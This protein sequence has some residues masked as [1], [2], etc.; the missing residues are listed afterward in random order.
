MVL[1]FVHVLVALDMN[2]IDVERLEMCNGLSDF[3]INQVV[4]AKCIARI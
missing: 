4:V 1:G 2:N 3:C